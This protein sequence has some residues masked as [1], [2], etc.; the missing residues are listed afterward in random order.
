MGV[1]VVELLVLAVCAIGVL[2][3]VAR[4]LSSFL[5]FFKVMGAGTTTLNCPH[6][7]QPTA[8][9]NGRCEACGRDL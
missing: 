4:G 2:L 5:G 9:G 1:G 8:P 6:C 3:F 7:G